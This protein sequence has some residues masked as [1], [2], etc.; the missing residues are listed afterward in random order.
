MVTS[1]HIKTKTKKTL[2]QVAKTGK[3]SKHMKIRKPKKKG[4][5]SGAVDNTGV[6][7]TV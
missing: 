3:H 7:I 4:L 1:G 2:I 5:T 6:I